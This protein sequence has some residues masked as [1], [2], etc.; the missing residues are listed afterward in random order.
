MALTSKQVVQRY[1]DALLVGDVDT[2]RESFAEEATW[3][4]HGDLPIAGPWLG[5]DQIVDDF[6]RA[7]GVPCSNRGASRSSSP[8]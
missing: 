3:T 1:L 6:L 5:R 4:M 2:I 7:V 8:P